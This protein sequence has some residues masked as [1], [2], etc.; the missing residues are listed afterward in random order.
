MPRM[1]MKKKRE[2][3]FFLNNRNRITYNKLCMQC[4]NG[5]SYA[6][7]GRYKKTN[8]TGK[9]RTMSEIVEDYMHIRLLNRKPLLQMEEAVYSE[10]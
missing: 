1:S 4:A 8:K 9:K 3:A 6:V 7:S 5:I 2:W 10:I